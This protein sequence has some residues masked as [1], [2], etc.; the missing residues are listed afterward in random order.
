MNDQA[1]R[2]HLIQL[3]EEEHAHVQFESA[4]KDFPP[5]LRGRRP[6]GTGHSAWELLEH[7]RIAQWD[8][9]EFSRDAGHVSPKWPAGYWP[10]SEG[11]PDE[12]A[13]DESVER[14]LADRRALADLVRDPAT[15]LFAPIAHGTGQTI[16]REAMLAADHNAYHVGQIVMVKKTLT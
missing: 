3:L 5:Q 16:L 9:L 4:V 12:R 2:D 6:D 1:L 8:I 10:D 7:L 13:W 14:F 11:P 15:D